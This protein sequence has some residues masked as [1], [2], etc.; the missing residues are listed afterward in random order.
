MLIHRAVAPFSAVLTHLVLDHA[1]GQSEQAVAAM[2]WLARNAAGV[3][4]IHCH[5]EF[6][7]SGCVSLVSCLPG[8][9]DVRLCLAGRTADDL[10]SLLEALAGCPRLK[11]LDLS[12]ECY[13]HSSMDS[14][15]TLSEVYSETGGEDEDLDPPF[16]DAAA[17]LAS[18]AKLSS[19]T[20]LALA[21]DN[22]EPYTLTDVVTALV[23]LTCLAE[24]CID[25]PHPPADVP[26]ALG[27][28]KGLRSLEM[29]GLGPCVLEVGC[30]ELPNLRSLHFYEC[31]FEGAEVLPGATALQCLAHFEFTGSRGPRFFDPGLVRLPLQRIV[32]THRHECGEHLRD[33]PRLLRLPADMGV[34]RSSLLHLNISGLRLPRF[35]PAVTQLAALECLD[36]SWNLFAKL[37]AGITALSRLTELRLGRVMCSLDPLQLEETRPLDVRAL[38]DLSGFPA[39]RELTLDFCEAKLC[40]SLLGAVR[41]TSLASLCFRS[42]HPAP[43]CLLVVLQLSQELRHLGR[44]G[45]VR[46]K[47]IA[48][49]PAL[50]FA[51]GWAPC[52][53][54]VAALEAGGL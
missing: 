24:L 41:H 20:K 48:G 53:K 1:D 51:Q 11:A 29:R 44:G 43:E 17:F 6:R 16:P 28:L 30:L 19:L 37:P 14:F 36:V 39:L 49:T 50:Q 47:N 10:G 46:V 21:M 18:L 45:V 33:P 3:R 22:A 12:M 13:D 32:M 2:D 7:A 27:Q 40:P 31:G 23:S 34:L 54:F 26:A 8:L 25:I 5:A 15:D 42:A 38:G 9:E 52:M 35:P 4:R